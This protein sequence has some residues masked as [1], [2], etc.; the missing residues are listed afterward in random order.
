MVL[1]HAYDP[2]LLE[3][4]AEAEAGRFPEVQAGWCG[5]HVKC[6][7]NLDYIAKH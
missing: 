4:E 1:A 3:A 6:Q 7:I 2:H 5:L